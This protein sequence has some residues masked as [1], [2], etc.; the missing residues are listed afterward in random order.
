MIGSLG[1]SPLSPL[2]SFCGIASVHLASKFCRLVRGRWLCKATSPLLHQAAWSKPLM[3]LEAFFSCALF[4]GAIR[5]GCNLTFRCR[6]LVRPSRTH[7]LWV[8]VDIF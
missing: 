1:F 4:L 5:L 7:F 6:T 8:G 2:S 3:Y